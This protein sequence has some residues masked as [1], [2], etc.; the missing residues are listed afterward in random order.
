MSHPARPAVRLKAIALAVLAIGVL[1][2]PSGEARNRKDAEEESDRPRLRLVAD[3][4]VGFSPVE[5]VVTA[6]LTGIAPDDSNFCHAAV[7]WIRIDPAHTE[8]E[9]LR[10]RENPACRH[11]DDESRVILSYTKR[12]VLRR[13]G[14]HMIRMRIEGKDG[15]TV[16]SG[17]TSIRVL[18]V[19]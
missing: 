4:A 10:V 1:Q 13:V 17:Y 15:R 8:D 12:F 16:E 9:P 19:Q 18:R 5:V 2:S 3:K 6:R 14:V 7:T 11:P